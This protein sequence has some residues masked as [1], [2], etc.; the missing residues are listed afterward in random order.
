MLHLK[1]KRELLCRVYK[2]LRSIRRKPCKQFICLINVSIYHG[3]TFIRWFYDIFLKN[4]TVEMNAIIIP[5]TNVFPSLKT[6]I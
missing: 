6:I 4:Y 2:K 5:N 1:K 3:E